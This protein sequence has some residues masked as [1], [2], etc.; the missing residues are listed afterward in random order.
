MTAQTLRQTLSPQTQSA[1]PILASS[2][3]SDEDLD[4]ILDFTLSDK[5]KASKLRNKKGALAIGLKSVDDALG[6]GLR[7]ASLVCVSGEVGSGQVGLSL[8]LLASHLLDHPTSTAAVIDTTGNLDVLRIYATLA[9]R[10]R[11]TPPQQS[12]VIDHADAEDIAAKILDRVKIM[13]V[14]D[15]E[16]IVEAVGEIRE[17]LDQVPTPP[18]NERLEDPPRPTEEPKKISKTV[19]QDSEDE[20]DEEDEMLFESAPKSQSPPN[21]DAAPPL[22]EPVK[23][24]DKEGAGPQGKVGFVLVDNIAHVISPVLKSNYIHA[25]AL[26]TALLQRLTHLTH[27]YSLITILLN[28]ASIPRAPT[29]PSSTTPSTSK[30]SFQPQ[31]QVPPQQSI[32]PPSIFASNLAVPALGNVLPMYLDMHLLVSKMPRGKADARAWYRDAG[33]VRSGGGGGSAGRGV[34]KRLQMVSVVEVLSERVEGRVG[35]WGVFVEDLDGGVGEA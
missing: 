25:N 18:M 21:P 24:L 34:V 30:P 13:R 17:G 16:G 31:P 23:G 10:L 22:S 29:Q 32:A 4:G 26:L 1:E 7:R 6:G 12:D 15:L 3:L 20:E 5:P 8:S 19:I 27:T 28:R 33:D 9:S 35:D 2:L 11:K 14:F